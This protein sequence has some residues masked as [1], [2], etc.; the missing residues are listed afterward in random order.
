MALIV[1][2][3]TED[4]LAEETVSLRFVCTIID[5]LRLQDFAVGVLENLL[6]RCQTDTNLGEV[7]LLIIFSKSHS[8]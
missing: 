6:G 2:D 1:L 3:R 7:G 4:A 5:S 8:L